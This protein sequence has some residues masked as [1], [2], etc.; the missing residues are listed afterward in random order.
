M[1][2]LVLS[3]ALVASAASSVLY[4]GVGNEENGANDKEIVASTGKEGF[5]NIKVEKPTLVKFYSE[6][7]MFIKKMI[8]RPGVNEVQIDDF[9]EGKYFVHLGNYSFI[10]LK[11]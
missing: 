4:A 2:K 6:D 11:K 8:V 7:G 10:L 5:I 1:K 9:R 3:L